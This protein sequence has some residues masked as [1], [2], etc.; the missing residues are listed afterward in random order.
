MSEERGGG[1]QLDASSIT[2]AVPASV[3]WGAILSM[4]G[5]VFGMY[6]TIRDLRAAVR[7][8][9]TT[10]HDLQN[11]PPW[12][13]ERVDRIDRRVHALEDKCRNMPNTVGPSPT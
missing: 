4:L 3:F 8:L 1:E 12:F 13:S 11:P 2:F 6:V 7:S 9:E 10:V 5:V